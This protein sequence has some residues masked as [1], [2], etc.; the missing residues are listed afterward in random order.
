MDDFK[1]SVSRER[2]AV[3]SDVRR[4][5]SSATAASV[6]VEVTTF[7]LSESDE[8]VSSAAGAAVSSVE[9]AKVSAVGLETGR[10]LLLRRMI[11]EE[12]G[13]S[14]RKFWSSCRW[15]WS[16]AVGSYS[17]ITILAVRILS[18]ALSMPID[19]TLSADS[20]RPA[21]SMKR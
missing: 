11:M 18:L 20:L 4:S 3:S 1:S 16:G 6:F 12:S 15:G 19:S 21:V 17:Q 14:V 13:L 7:V 2:V 5:A 10:S 8:F 9:G